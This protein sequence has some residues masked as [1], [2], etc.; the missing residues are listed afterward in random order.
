MVRCIFSKPPNTARPDFTC[1]HLCGSITCMQVTFTFVSELTLRLNLTCKIVR[2][3][4]LLHNYIR[5]PKY[6][7][8][9]RNVSRSDKYYNS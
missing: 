9:G 2:L 6:K 4:N 1:M 5:F 8:Q 3:Y 7:H